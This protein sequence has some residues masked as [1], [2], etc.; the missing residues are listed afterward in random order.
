MS[1]ISN[2]DAVV[3]ESKLTEFYNDIKPYLGCP[4][5]LTSEGTSDYYSTDEKVIGRWIDG[6]PL[7][8]KTVN[9][10]VYT[11]GNIPKDGNSIAIPNLRAELNIENVIIGY[12]SRTNC[13]TNP[14]ILW[15]DANS[16]QLMIE[17]TDTMAYSSSI[18]RY[19]TIRYTKTTDSAS[20]T[21]QE[22]PNEYSTDEKIIGKWIDGK[23]IYQRTFALTLHPTAPAAETLT[24]HGITDLSKVIDIRGY[25]YA[26]SV[27]YSLSLPRSSNTQ[28]KDNIDI[29]VDN[30]NIHF[31]DCPTTATEAYVTLQ[32]TKTTD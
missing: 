17:G 23:P 4:A 7:Y 20:T 30:T 13:Y 18:I 8:Q 5:Y 28:L 27:N 12:L 31:V 21:I 2:T 32:Y 14:A 29:Y 15:I 25:W 19:L 3:T 9:V 16:N 1:N 26:G 24:A 10:D 6:K 22:D 11:T